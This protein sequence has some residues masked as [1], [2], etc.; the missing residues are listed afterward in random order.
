MASLPA[1]GANRYDFTAV[2]VIG[3]ETIYLKTQFSLL[4]HEQLLEYLY[5]NLARRDSPRNC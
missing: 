3:M 2:G 1:E 4:T 5:V